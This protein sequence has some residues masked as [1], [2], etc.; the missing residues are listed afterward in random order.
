MEIDIPRREWNRIKDNPRVTFYA[1]AMLKIGEN[2]PGY[3]RNLTEHIHY[4]GGAIRGLIPSY[5][6]VRA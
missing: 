6:R 5:T 3:A 1:G 4:V 2:E